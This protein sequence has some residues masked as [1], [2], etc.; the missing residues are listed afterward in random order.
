MVII[1]YV[2]GAMQTVDYSF[3]HGLILLRQLAALATGV[4]RR[5]QRGQ[6]R[7]LSTQELDMLLVIE[8]HVVRQ[9]RQGIG[10]RRRR[11]RRGRGSHSRRRRGRRGRGAARS[12]FASGTAAHH[13]EHCNDAPTS[14]ATTP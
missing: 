9:D 5:G 6:Q 1:C 10:R 11:A 7:V 2:Y 4:R 13:D 3:S 8:R 12:D 14:T